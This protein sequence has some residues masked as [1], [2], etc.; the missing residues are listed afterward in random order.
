MCIILGGRVYLFYHVVVFFFLLAHS[1]SSTNFQCRFFCS[2][3]FITRLPESIC[4]MKLE[5]LAVN[6]NNLSELP[7]E[8]GRMQELRLLVSVLL[9]CTIVSTLFL[10]LSTIRN[11]FLIRILN[12]ALS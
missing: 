6:N 8:I 5:S 2:R 10:V 7:N 9:F 3:N 4:G 11:F 12:F 1:C